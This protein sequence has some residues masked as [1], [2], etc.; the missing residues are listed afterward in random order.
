MV[1]GLLFLHGL[2]SFLSLAERIELTMTSEI[3]NYGKSCFGLTVGKE[4]AC[5]TPVWT[6]E[7]IGE[8][9]NLEWH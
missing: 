7:T 6:G 3:Y 4:K 9:V 5:T 8:E 1:D 2:S